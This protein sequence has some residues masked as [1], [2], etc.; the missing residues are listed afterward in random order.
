MQDFVACSEKINKGFW[1]KGYLRKM[2]YER[3]CFRYIEN[4]SLYKDR[5]TAR[6]MC[7][8]LKM[9]LLNI[10][11]LFG[12]IKQKDRNWRDCAYFDKLFTSNYEQL[13]IKD[14]D[15][16]RFLKAKEF[17]ELE[18]RKDKD[19]EWC[20]AS[21]LNPSLDNLYEIPDYSKSSEEEK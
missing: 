16:I 21:P 15:G 8:E 14:K 10:P 4:L 12:W 9:P 18:K 2:P 1:F 19:F 5:E 17:P 6:R 7:R 20:L 3:F 11:E 13:V